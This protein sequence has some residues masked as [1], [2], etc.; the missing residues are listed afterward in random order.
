MAG[1]GFRDLF[2]D[3]A[4]FKQ[5]EKFFRFDFESLRV[6]FPVACYEKLSCCNE[7]L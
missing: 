6:L 2:A 7:N 3:A 5:A 1:F 4:I